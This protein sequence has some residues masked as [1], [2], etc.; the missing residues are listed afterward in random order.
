MDIANNLFL[1]V[2]MLLVAATWYLVI[3]SLL[4]VGQHYLERFF[5]KGASRQL[6]A[7]QLAALADAEGKPPANVT[8]T[9][10]N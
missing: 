6:T 1:P 9:D 7:R 5:S 3:T 10:E 8:I 2:P 4:M